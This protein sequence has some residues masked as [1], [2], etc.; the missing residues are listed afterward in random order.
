M[1]SAS[2]TINDLYLGATHNMG[3]IKEIGVGGGKWVEVRE[4]ASESDKH[5]DWMKGKR[6]YNVGKDLLGTNDE[7][8]MKSVTGEG[9]AW[10][11]E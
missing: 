6:G 2:T 3:N 1:S 5:L 8:S 9:E 7:E 10:L 4:G 11:S